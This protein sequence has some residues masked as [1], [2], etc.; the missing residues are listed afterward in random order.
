[1]GPDGKTPIRVLVYEDR[2]IGE[3]SY[4][5]TVMLIEQAAGTLIFEP[6]KARR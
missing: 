4:L 5:D 3:L 6:D 2:V 1:M